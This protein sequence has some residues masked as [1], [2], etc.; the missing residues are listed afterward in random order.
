[1]KWNKKEVS[2]ELIKELTGRYGCDQLTASILARR[3]VIEGP[4]ILF[5]LEDDLRYIHNPFLFRSM[6]DAVDRVLDAKEE[7]EKILVFGDRDVDGIT[8]TTLLVQ[9]LTDLGMD[10]SWRVPEGND[11][12]GLTIAAVDE[13]AAASGTLIITVDCGISCIPEIAHACEL[14]ID[15]IV[16]DHHNPQEELPAAVAIINPKMTDSGYPFRDLAGCAVV[17]KFISA[18]RFG[19]LELYK[20]QVC[21]LNVRPANE[22]YIIEAIQTVNMTETARISETIVPGMVSIT[23][24]RLLP[25]LQGQQIFVWDAPA[26]KRQLSAIFGKGVEFNLLD[27][28]PE[29]SRE[30]PAIRSMSLLR[31]K[32]ISRIGRYQNKPIGELEGFFNIFV[33][34]MQRKNAVFGKR[35]T[36]ELQLAALG[37]L[38]DLMPLENENRIL[39]RHGLAAI[40]KQPRAGLAE[41][42]ARQGLS[43]KK[44][45]TSDLAWQISPAIN[46][47]G[48]MGNPGLAV[49]LLMSDDQDERNR[50]S[51]EVIRLNTD[52]K[53]MGSDS[54]AIV[55]PIARESLERFHSRLVLAASGEIH[56]GVT[57]IMANRLS[58]C[59][60]VPAIVIC[61]MEDG[62][63]IGSMRSARG[64]RLDGLLAPCADLFL[65]HGGHTFAAGFS[66]PMDR[67]EEF[68]SRIE[69]ISAEIVFPEG[70][71]DEEL[72][73][74]AEL[75]HEYLTPSL[76]ELTDRFEPYGEGNEPLLFMARGLRVISADIMGKTEKQHLKLTFDCGKFKWPAIFWQAAER[77]GR[78]FSVGDSVDAV[79]QA[80]R[81]TFNG[82]ETPQ[83]ILQ[84]IKRSAG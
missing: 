8:S 81:N 61:F 75:P 46:A 15:V 39:V 56:R 52:R 7:G 67:L 59:F 16:L 10:V 32:D 54:W 74:D 70:D 62:T 40:N 48:R 4:D 44:V 64:Y 51:E 65:D 42:L 71:A 6:E 43:G 80:S 78:D 25:F 38:A 66:F 68:V 79:F 21:L 57:G 29:I 34:F 31:L 84:D 17:W 33:T 22:S 47:T 23:Q 18:L 63:A 77:L 20:Q 1:M 58:S 60:Q 50:L 5:Y 11:P 45:G 28:G 37:T 27:M 9:A 82:S 73:I 24:T 41:L 19:L 83:M 55:E 26:Q 2:R 12:Y 14:G 72:F 76:L 49:R 30:I 36:E 69:R 53:Q 35:E 3:G 13:H